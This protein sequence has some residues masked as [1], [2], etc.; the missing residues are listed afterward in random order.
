MGA[1][2]RLGVVDAVYCRPLFQRLAPGAGFTALHDVPSAH[3]ISLR[4]HTL[5]V[6]F[7]TPIDYARESSTYRILPNVGVASTRPTGSIGLF[8]RDAIHTIASIAIDPS[9]LSEI[10][11]ARIILA[12]EFNL[13]PKF[14]P[15]A[16]TLDQQLEKHD[17]VLLVGDASLAGVEHHPN[18]I[19]LVESWLDLTDLPYLHGVWCAHEGDLTPAE[20]QKIRETAVLG[21]TSLGDLA[22]ELYRSPSPPLASPRLF[23]RYW[24]A[25]S[26]SLT[27]EDL[28]G[29][30]EFLRYAFYHGVLPDVAE[31]HFYTTDDTPPVD[32][33]ALKN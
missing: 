33:P 14:V 13:N 3:A 27:E 20:V 7:L 12:E 30:S 9:S 15:S 2:K 31:L 8:F 23:R 18:H 22:D 25:F 10:V 19:D 17:A 4:N 24:D 26:Y 16:G 28:E 5:D 29:F 11:L 6:G 32:D 1:N 21:M